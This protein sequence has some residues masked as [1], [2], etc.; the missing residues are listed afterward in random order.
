MN[1]TMATYQSLLDSLNSIEKMKEIS[2]LVTKP[3]EGASEDSPLLAKLMAE[4]RVPWTDGGDL[5]EWN[6]VSAEKEAVVS[7]YRAA[8]THSEPEFL[9]KATM[10]YVRYRAS[11]M[12]FIG[13]A[14]KQR[15]NKLGFASYVARIMDDALKGFGIRFDN[16]A[17]NLTADTSFTV[18][19][20]DAL[21]RSM[22]ADNHAVG[23]TT[24]LEA[25]DQVGL[26]GTAASPSGFYAGKTRSSSTG[27]LN[28]NAV[29]VPGGL[30]GLQKTHLE[31]AIALATHGS[32]GSPNLAIL[33]DPQYLKVK[34][35]VATEL[36]DSLAKDDF[37]NSLGYQNFVWSGVTWVASKRITATTS[38]G[39]VTTARSRF[40]L[41]NT[42]HILL[43]VV[44]EE[45]CT[46]RD[47]IILEGQ[48]AIRRDA[49]FNFCLCVS[50]PRCH[51]V[52]YN[53]T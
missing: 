33:D 39:K 32:L 7:D 37:F 23:L 35:L 29:Y 45:A 24:A 42:K 11:A 5:Y 40:E 2:T 19:G 18:A 43:P 6:I 48:D 17:F 16:E 21:G 28:N 26:S 52:V 44:P 4:S 3:A 41:L 53:L 25:Y 10:K 12:Y 14:M 50:N 30:A 1:I 38:A 31:R 8:I 47:P 46:W 9:V 51:T 36:K 15:S 34:S 20:T 22:S 49:Y 27:Y 13:E